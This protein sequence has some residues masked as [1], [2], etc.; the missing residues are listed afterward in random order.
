MNDLLNKKL[1]AENNKPSEEV[2][3]NIL[4]KKT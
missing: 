2:I 3:I 1:I 4:K